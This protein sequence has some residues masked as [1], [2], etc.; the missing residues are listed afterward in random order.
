MRS[1]FVTACLLAN[2][3]FVA[4]AAWSVFN[5]TNAVSGKHDANVTY[6]HKVASAQDCEAL[7]DLHSAS[8]FTWCSKAC[9][10]QYMLTCALRLDGVWRTVA[11]TGHTSGFNGALPPTPSPPSP[12]PPAPPCSLNGDV[13]NSGGCICDKGWRGKI[14]GQLNLLPAPPLAAQV[15]SKAALA[16]DNGAANATWGM[17][18]IGPINGTFHGI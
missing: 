8:I 18:V 14:C 15:S 3:V 4:D 13:T 1:A 17:S 10:T 16:H 12:A 11:Q 5:S 9:E 2:A 7:A 6:F